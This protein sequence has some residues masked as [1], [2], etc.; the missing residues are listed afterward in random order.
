MDDRETTDGLQAKPRGAPETKAAFSELEGDSSM[1]M[2]VEMCMTETLHGRLTVR[3]W[4][5]EGSTRTRCID[6]TA[7]SWSWAI[8]WPTGAP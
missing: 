6:G 5:K 1:R 8:R 7:G 2:E 3:S 4:T